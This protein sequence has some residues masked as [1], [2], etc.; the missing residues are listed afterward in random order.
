MR[1]PNLWP[2]W[3]LC[4]AS[5]SR[6]LTLGKLSIRTNW[7]ASS[8]RHPSLKLSLI[9]AGTWTSKWIR[10]AEKRFSNSCSTWLLLN[11]FRFKVAFIVRKKGKHLRKKHNKS[12]RFNLYCQ[13]RMIH[14]ILKKSKDMEPKMKNLQI[15]TWMITDSVIELFLDSKSKVILFN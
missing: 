10:W 1:F 2:T 7:S 8:A 3:S 12:N 6:S 5:T 14:L 13:Q 11:L 4:R 15:W 9:C